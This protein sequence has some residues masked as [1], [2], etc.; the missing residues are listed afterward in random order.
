MMPT[1]IGVGDTVTSKAVQTEEGMKFQR[2][3]SDRG[4]LE[5]IQALGRKFKRDNVVVYIDSSGGE[6]K[7][8][9]RLKLEN[10]KDRNLQQELRVI[11]G[12]GDS[13]DNSDPLS[14]NLLLPGGHQQYIQ[15]FKTAANFRCKE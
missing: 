12:P 14:L 4:F 5:L 3:G 6:I 9:K 15:I 10:V 7:N 8:R 11:E 2:G 1:I 13:R